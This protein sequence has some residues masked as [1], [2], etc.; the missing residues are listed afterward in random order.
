[1]FYKSLKRV[2]IFLGHQ[3]MTLDSRSVNFAYHA[4]QTWVSLKN[5]LMTI[6]DFQFMLICDGWLWLTFSANGNV[7]L[8]AIF[9]QRLCGGAQHGL[10]S[11]AGQQA[12]HPGEHDPL[13]RGSGGVR[14]LVQV[15]RRQRRCVVVHVPQHRVRLGRHAASRL[16]RCRNLHLFAYGVFSVAATD[17]WTYCKQIIYRSSFCDINYSNIMY[18]SL[19]FIF[20]LMF[21]NNYWFY[22]MCIRKFSAKKFSDWEFLNICLCNK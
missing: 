21:V 9:L 10:L 2:Q 6:R 17:C 7:N 8:R 14:R 20:I 3:V 4:L 18:A 11:A 5:S 13:R 19:L 22:H 12:G 1:M 15:A 16:C